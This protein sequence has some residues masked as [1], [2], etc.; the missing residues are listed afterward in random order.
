MPVP[1]YRPYS[2]IK[3]PLLWSLFYLR[4]NLT[5]EEAVKDIISKGGDTRANA[6]IVGGLIGAANGIGDSQK[7]I[8]GIKDVLDNL[9]EILK[10]APTTLRVNWSGKSLTGVEDLDSHFRIEKL[11]RNWY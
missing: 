6:A 10:K 8:V 4:K 1:H 11:I 9:T 3:T 2:Y 5:Y 7:E